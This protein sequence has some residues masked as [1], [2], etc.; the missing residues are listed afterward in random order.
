M[1][2]QQSHLVITTQRYTQIVTGGYARC[3]YFVFVFN[4]RPHLLS[5]LLSAPITIQRIWIVLGRCLFTT[6]RGVLEKSFFKSIW[7]EWFLKW[8]IKRVVKKIGVL[9]VLNKSEERSEKRVVFVH[10]A[11]FERAKN[12]CAKK[13]SISEQNFFVHVRHLKAVFCNFWGLWGLVMILY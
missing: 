13:F 6:R 1:H 2:L 9:L 5:R 8:E 7:L 12:W 4:S 11:V 3:V 10:T